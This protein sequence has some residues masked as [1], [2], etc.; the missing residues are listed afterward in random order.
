MNRYRV[1]YRYGTSSGERT[2][3]LRGGTESEA[4]TELRKQCPSDVQVV[5]I[6][7]VLTKNT[8]GQSQ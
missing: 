3:E 8:D 4:L 6:T 7:R 5:S 2:L 1:K